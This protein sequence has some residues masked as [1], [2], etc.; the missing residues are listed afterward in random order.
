MEN[1]NI[2]LRRARLS[3]IASPLIALL[4]GT[5]L[6]LTAHAQTTVEYIHTDALGSPVAITDASGNIVEREV[7]EPYGSPITRPPSDQPGFTGH[8]VDSLTSLTYMQQRYYDPQI[9]MFL[10]VDPVTAYSNPVGAFNRYWYANNNPYRFI[11][12]NGRAADDKDSSQPITDLP[13]VNVTARYQGPGA[14]F[15]TFEEA[16]RQATAFATENKR[17]GFWDR[18]F[19][20]QDPMYFVRT[21]SD[22]PELYT[23]EELI[24]L[25]GITP[26]PAL[27]SGGAL[28]ALGNLKG[29]QNMT[30]SQA[31]RTRGGGGSQV[32]QIATNLREL[33]LSDVAKL[34]AGGNKEAI[35]AIKMI[36]QAST[37]AERY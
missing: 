3:S 28:R 34:A 32:Q 22:F 18:F 19:N 12:P 15:A 26:T 31:I 14:L 23:Y 9:G 11:D 13:P 20:G 8:V 2:T 27:L 29:M 24:A 7:Y 30:V 35:K 37:K 33:P 25:T 16:Q 1:R 36:K 6:S 21:D 10:S 5:F 4:L 17:S